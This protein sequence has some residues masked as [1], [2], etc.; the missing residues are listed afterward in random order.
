MILRNQ[1]ITIFGGSGFIGRHVVKELAKTGAKINVISRTPNNSLYL[2]TTGS[3]GQI[4]L[5]K[6][7]V[8]NTDHV[9]NLVKNSDIV[10]NAVGILYET[11]RQKF[12]NIHSK[13]P[14]TLGKLST[15]YNIKKLIHISALAID[16]NINSKYAATKLQGEESIRNK[17]PNTTIIRPSIVFG[18]DDTFFNKF[19]QI[20]NLS[21]IIPII[22]KGNTKFQPVYVA[23]IAKSIYKITTSSN[24]YSGKTYEL[25]GPDVYTLKELWKET[26]TQ[27]EK[28]RAFINIPFSLA[29]IFSVI[30]ELFPNPIITRDQI[31]LLQNHNITQEKSETFFHLQIQPHKISEIIPTYLDRYKSHCYHTNN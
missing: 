12:T 26:L 4:S 11:K 7:N 20:A 1:T 19:A 16:K 24:K 8:N 31:K 22:G 23:D 6:G 17:F 9:H 10:I 2:K 13:F 30:L 27:I 15:Q 29:N 18:A 25:G 14:E 3:V 28:K 21:P 5:I